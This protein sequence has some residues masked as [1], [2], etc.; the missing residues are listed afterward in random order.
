MLGKSYTKV[1]LG[2]ETIMGLNISVRILMIRPYYDLGF[3]REA[4]Y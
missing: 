2:I 4:R 1:V 3:H